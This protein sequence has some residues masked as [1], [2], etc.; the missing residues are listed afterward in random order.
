[1]PEAWCLLV[2]QRSVHS[3]DVNVDIDVWLGGHKS[4]KLRNFKVRDFFAWKSGGMISFWTISC[5]GKFLKRKISGSGELKILRS[6][7]GSDSTIEYDRLW[8][9]RH[10]GPGLRWYHTGD[11]L[12]IIQSTTYQHIF[13]A[14]QEV[15]KHPTNQAISFCK[16]D[17]STDKDSFR[18]VQLHHHTVTK[19]I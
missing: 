5:L 1:M 6:S 13:D 7:R 11:K 2:L 12:P 15:L 16:T 4:C 17:S 19:N 18:Q 8:T 3:G 10:D 14:D 9:C